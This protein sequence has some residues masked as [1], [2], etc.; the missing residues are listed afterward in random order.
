MPITTL[1]TG[2]STGHQRRAFV[3]GVR[4]ERLRAQRDNAT[5]KAIITQVS[6]WDEGS[7]A[8]SATGMT[9]L[10]CRPPLPKKKNHRVYIGGDEVRIKNKGILQHTTSFTQETTSWIC[11]RPFCISIW[12]LS[13]RE[14]LRVKRSEEAQTKRIHKSSR[15]CEGLNKVWCCEIFWARKLFFFCFFLMVT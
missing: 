7:K 9:P 10:R 1:N 14:T 8:A 4:N 2:V 3:E 6:G 15:R 13:Q 11:D 12:M 5:R